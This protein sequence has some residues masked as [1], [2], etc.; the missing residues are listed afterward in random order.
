MLSLAASTVY[1]ILGG[2]AAL[3]LWVLAYR[4]ES[5][6]RVRRGTDR[7]RTA[8]TGR[9]DWS[10]LKLEHLL[11]P[12][13]ALTVFNVAYNLSRVHCADDSLAILASGRAAL[14]GH[15]P[16]LVNYCGSTSPDPIP[17]G[18]AEVALNATAALSGSVA[19]IWVLWQGLGLLVVPLVWWV[20]G[21]D[22]R[23]LAVL[24][25]SSVLYLPNIL[26]N[27]G[28]ENLVVPVAVL[29]GLAAFR[30]ARSA[31]PLLL[32]VAAFLSTAR[33]PA[34]F[35]LLA[36]AGSRPERR[37]RGAL[38][39]AG[40]FLGSAALCYAL[41]GWDAIKTIYLGQFVRVP[42]E[43]LN[44]FAF[45][46]RQP[47]F[48]PSLASA[49]VQGAV[50]LALVVVAS[51][52]GYSAPAACGIPLLGV[53]LL[54]QYLTFHFVAWLVPLVLLGPSV[55]AGL[56]LYGVVAGLDETLLL[57]YLALDKGIWWP[58]EL[59]GFALTALLLAVLVRIVLDEERRLR[60]TAGASASH[61][62]VGGGPARSGGP[63]SKAAPPAAH[64]GGSEVQSAG[65]AGGPSPAAPSDAG[66]SRTPRVRSPR[67]DASAAASDG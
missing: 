43:S 35:P 3:N 31:R 61:P 27:I 67:L 26:T 52:R 20:G 59:A 51:V 40:V 33:F 44:A 64:P 66:D 38:L 36:A 63:A 49:A 30:L 1:W 53:M 34:V 58:Y 14:A 60:R 22:R 7:I 28:V 21:D 25:G 57:W 17:Y 4:W 23:Y 6:P 47:W 29:A 5:F 46:L 10:W 48:T 19:G 9:R 32:G 37:L 41:W 15:T 8:F 54:S 12:L 24:A 2:S 18:L 62:D 55:N 50:L 65:W 11:I 13:A 16:F 56:L 42:G 45:L 39:V